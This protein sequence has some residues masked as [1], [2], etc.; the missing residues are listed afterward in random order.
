MK[1]KKQ[2]DLTAKTAFNSTKLLLVVFLSLGLRA[3]SL[4]DDSNLPFLQRG[5][6]RRPVA[7]IAR[8]SHETSRT[9]IEP[10]QQLVG[11]LIFLA[12]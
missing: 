9:A 11:V 3:M 8:L 7:R 10:S 5:N 4:A 1:F 2:A 12:L 6:F